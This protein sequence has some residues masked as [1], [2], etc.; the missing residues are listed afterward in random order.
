M[1]WIATPESSNI[2]GFQYD[3]QS[4]I[5]LVEFKDGAR[6]NYYDVPVDIFEGMK[7]AGSKGQYLAQ[8]IKARFRYARL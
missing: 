4:M 6:Y 5:L 3:A 7:A 2:N 1:N 8:N